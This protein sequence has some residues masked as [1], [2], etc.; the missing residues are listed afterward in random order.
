MK[1]TLSWLFDHLDTAAS[2]E[3]LTTTLSAIGLEVDGVGLR[4]TKGN[5]RS[6]FGEGS[7]LAPISTQEC[8]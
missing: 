4:Q 7:F 2:L 1:F 8:V 5:R 6:G 3:E